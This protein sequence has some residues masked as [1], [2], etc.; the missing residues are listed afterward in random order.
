VLTATGPAVLLLA[1]VLAG[2]VGTAGGITSL[3]SYP[4]L[5]A[6]GVPAL[7]ANAA[8]LVAAVACWPGAALVSRR[9]LAGSLRWLARGLP[10]AAAGAATGTGLLLATPPGVFSRVVPFLVAVGAL[11][12]LTQPWLSARTRSAHRGPVASTLAG[13]GVLSVYSGYFGA[14]SGVLLLALL[15]V[16]VDDRLPQA[17]AGKNMLLGACG[18]ASAAVLVVVGAVEWEVVAPLA[19]GLFLGSLAGPVLA[20]RLPAPVVR[21][22]VAVLGLGLAVR[23]WLHPA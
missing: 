5:L 2:A 13:V 10:V 18:C 11:V 4:A 6:V 21:W 9:E 12:L 19:A 15:L 22:A 16:L 7:P 20:R 17:N 14:G 1:G 23:L 8:N 3:V